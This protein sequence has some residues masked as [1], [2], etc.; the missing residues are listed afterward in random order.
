MVRQKATAERQTSWLGVPVGLM[1][2]MFGLLP[3]LIAGE[4]LPLQNLWAQPTLPHEMPWAA[5][6]ISQ[7]YVVRVLSLLVI[8]SALAGVVA[9]ALRSSGGTLASWQIWLGASLVQWAAIIQSFV[10]LAIGLDLAG[11]G[12]GS[13]VWVYWGG[14]LGSTLLAWGL[15]MATFWMISR[16]SRPAFAIGVA[17]AAAPLTAWVETAFLSQLYPWDLPPLLQTALPWLSALLVGAALGR[18]GLRR[19][20]DVAAWIVSAGLLVIAPGL[21]EALEWTF[22]S[23]RMARGDLLEMIIWGA[24]GLGPGIEAAALPMLGGLGVGALIAGL[25]AAR[26]RHPASS[27]RQLGD[28]W[29][30]E[31]RLRAAFAAAPRARFLPDDQRDLADWDAPLPIGHGATNSQPTTVAN[32][33]ELLD[34]QPG[35]RVLDVGAGSGWTTALLANLVGPEGRVLG[36]ERIAALLP[37]ATAAIAEWDWASIRLAQKGTFGLPDDGPFDRILVS[38]MARSIPSQLTDQLSEG[39][40]MVIPVDSVMLRVMKDAAGTIETTSHG[41]YRFVPLVD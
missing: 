37:A 22:G 31:P 11:Q 2:A 23:A 34:V 20:Q 24:G 26:S 10:V 15:G 35:Q 16:G 41:M 27:G 30:M 28:N 5:L 29:L 40:V 12:P 33:L 18:C 19:R 8:G 1:A 4:P 25:R 7:Y 38:A 6:P 9:R 36:V 39:G 3:W 14:M 17:I 21:L 32:M 13:R